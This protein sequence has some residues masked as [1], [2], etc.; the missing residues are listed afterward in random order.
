MAAL[1]IYFV[2]ASL[3]FNCH[4][5]LRFCGKHSFWLLLEAVLPLL[6]AQPEGRC[7]T[8]HAWQ[9]LCWALYVHARVH[10]I[11]SAHGSKVRNWASDMSQ[12]FS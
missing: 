3:E 8:T 5:H 9:H 10:G 2:A 4:A 7:C 12:L 1:T 11:S 6:V